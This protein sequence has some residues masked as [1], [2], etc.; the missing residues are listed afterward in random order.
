[1]TK[2]TDA[3]EDIGKCNCCKSV[4][5]KV[6]INQFYWSFLDDIA[7]AKGSTVEELCKEAINDYVRKQF[8]DAVME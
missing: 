5:V 4:E 6:S 2:L 7:D 8:I 1:M 3:V